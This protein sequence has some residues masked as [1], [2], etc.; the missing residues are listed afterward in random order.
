LE[1][2]AL[3][4]LP[5]LLAVAS[6]AACGGDPS[7]DKGPVGSPSNPAPALPNPAGTRTPP[8]VTAS[9]TAKAPARHAT[10]RPVRGRVPRPNSAAARSTQGSRAAKAKPTARRTSARKQKGTAPGANSPCALVTKAQAQAIVGT[11]LVE[12]LQAPQGPTCIYQTATGKQQVTLSVQRVDFADL[13]KQLR[14]SRRVLV[15]SK[16]GYCG[17]YGRPMLYVPLSG[18][19]L[20]IAGPCGV[21]SKFA[22]RAL[23]LL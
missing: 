22:A 9:E 2:R 20:T 6:L 1:R 10:A 5:V 3:G 16:T 12:P 8:D 14:N 21:A 17:T 11:K 19:V 13:R 4:A 18:G 15:S 23:P 7:A